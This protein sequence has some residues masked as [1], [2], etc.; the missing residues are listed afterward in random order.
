MKTPSTPKTPETPKPV[1]PTPVSNKETWCVPKAGVSDAQLQSNLDYACGR[2]ID[3][4]PIQ[5][6][7]VCFEP[8][9]VA[10]HA[11]YAMNLLYQNSD[12]SPGNCDFSQTGTLSSKNPSKFLS[13]MVFWNFTYFLN[14]SLD[15]C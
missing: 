7:G 8:N 9:T 1:T 15:E 13:S 12:R 11:A 6:G 2:G 4:S 10:S 5:P 14:F 3:C